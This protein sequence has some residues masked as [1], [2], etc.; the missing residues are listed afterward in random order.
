MCVQEPALKVANIVPGVCVV[1]AFCGGGGT[2]IVFAPAGKKKVIAI[3]LDAEGL[4]MAKY[5]AC[6]FGVE[7]NIF[8]LFEMIA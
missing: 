5:N 6:I 8:F 1:D 7:K 2:A 4:E 3:D